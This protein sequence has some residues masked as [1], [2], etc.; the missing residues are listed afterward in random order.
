MPEQEIKQEDGV[1]AEQAAH[2]AD[3]KDDAQKEGENA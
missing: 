2:G 3:I 1:I